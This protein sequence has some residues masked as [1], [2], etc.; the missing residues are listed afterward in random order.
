MTTHFPAGSSM[1]NDLPVD[2]VNEMWTAQQLGT[3]VLS[4]SSDPR[5]G[6]STMT[7]ENI[8]AGEP[9]P[10]LLRPP[11]GYRV[12]DETGPFAVKLP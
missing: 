2:S 3:T 4:K 1:G 8:V 6:D 12:V 7:L 11:A 10:S 5:S 9:D